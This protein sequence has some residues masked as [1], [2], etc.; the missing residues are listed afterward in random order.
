MSKKT[1]QTVR[2]Q[3]SP[4][5]NSQPGKYYP[6]GMLRD[7]QRPAIVEE[8]KRLGDWE[9]DTMIGKKSPYAL[10]TLIERKLR[11]TWLKKINRR[12]AAAAKEAMIQILKLYPL[13]TLT[14]TCDN[15][16]EFAGHQE[17]AEELNT[18]VYFVY[19]FSSWERATNENTNGLT[20]QYFPKGS[21]FSKIT[22]EKVQFAEK[23]LNTRPRKCLDISTPEMVF[24]KLSNVA[25]V[26]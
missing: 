7:E 19:P 24:F 25:L 1:A 17:I 18:E 12:T 11:F 4:R 13:R 6:R 3:R 21:D 15:G 20:R 14:I 5:K 16:R 10:V 2:E 23:R 26:T 9:A 22:D 8:R